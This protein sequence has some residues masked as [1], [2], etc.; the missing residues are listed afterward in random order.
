M[1][2]S[3]NLY[4]QV[5]IADILRGRKEDTSLT[6]T[7]IYN[8]LTKRHNFKGTRKTVERNLHGMSNDFKLSSIG[9]KPARYWIDDYFEPDL[10]I[11]LNPYQIQLIT[12]AIRNLAQTSSPPLRKTLKETEAALFTNLP[13]LTKKE[14]SHSLRIYEDN[15][16]AQSHQSWP[17][18]NLELLFLCARK[19]LLFSAKLKLSGLSFEE[20]HR[21]RNFHIQKLWFDSGELYL[22]VMETET[23]KTYKLKGSNFNGV[24]VHI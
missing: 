17:K 9:V 20:R 3:K 19:N 1:K 2:I 6:I 14:L 24:K 16:K 21:E 23:N 13:D 18:N 8:Q 22:K 5:Q 7:E 4:I 12:Y 15:R 11:G 10:K